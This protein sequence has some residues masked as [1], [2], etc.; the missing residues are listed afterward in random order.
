MFLLFNFITGVVPSNGAPN[1]LLQKSVL[2][3]GSWS[4]DT[5]V[6]SAQI[7]FGPA[8]LDALL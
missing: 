2:S 4:F 7:S 1:G 8:A 5:P 3:G 6:G